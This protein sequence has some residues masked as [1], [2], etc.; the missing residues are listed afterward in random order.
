[1]PSKL[2]REDAAHGDD[3]AKRKEEGACGKKPGRS[4]SAPGI[5]ILRKK[6]ALCR[7]AG[8]A[9][10]VRRPPCRL[11]T[12]LQGHRV[13]A[14]RLTYRSGR[15]DHWLKIKRQRPQNA[16]PR[17]IRVIGVAGGEEADTDDTAEIRSHL[18]G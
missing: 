9:D 14:P 13:E 7:L 3:A 2:T 1:M 4:L 18:G 17:R 16:R 6:S 8:A 12:R 10:E 5:K 11:R 15:V